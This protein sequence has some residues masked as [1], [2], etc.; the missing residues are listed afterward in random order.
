MACPGRTVRVLSSRESGSGLQIRPGGL[1]DCS[2]DTTPPRSVRGKCAT[3]SAWKPPTSSSGTRLGLPQKIQSL[4]L[5]L[6][7]RTLPPFFPPPALLEP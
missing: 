5:L 2:L 7:L 3:S 4:P 1:H 6:P